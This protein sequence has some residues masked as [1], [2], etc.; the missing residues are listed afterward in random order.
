MVNLRKGA[1]GN[2]NRSGEL[3]GPNIVSRMNL[4]MYFW[5]GKQISIAKV[6]LNF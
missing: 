1:P 3:R 5:L 4:V 6:I 2:L